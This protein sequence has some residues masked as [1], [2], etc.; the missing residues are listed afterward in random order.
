VAN[1]NHVD[2]ASKWQSRV[3][4]PCDPDEHD[5]QLNGICF[6]CD[7]TREALISFA[8]R[9]LKYFKAKGAVEKR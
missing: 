8:K 9:T 4:V 6:N 3:Y 1:K 5:F 7:W 2:F